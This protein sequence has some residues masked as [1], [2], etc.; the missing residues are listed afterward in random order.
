MNKEEKKVV[1]LLYNNNI[2]KLDKT[3][4]TDIIF[5]HDTY[6]YEEIWIKPNYDKQNNN[7]NI[8]NFYWFHLYRYIGEFEKPHLLLVRGKMGNTVEKKIFLE[9]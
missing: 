2:D 3:Y 4:N 7:D 6:N 9:A 5:Y 8:F 1:K